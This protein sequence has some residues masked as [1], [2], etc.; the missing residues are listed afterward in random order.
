MRRKLI[1][2][3][4]KMNGAGNDFIVIDNRFFH[5]SG[6]ELSGLARTFC[7]RRTGIGADGLLA[8]AMPAEEGAHFTMHYYNADGSLGTM[9]GNGA[10][11]LV[12]FAR[13]AG[14]SAQPLVFDAVSGR[15]TA[16]VTEGENASVRIRMNPARD[17]RPRLQL[18]QESRPAQ[19]VDYVWTGTEHTVV[20][21]HDVDRE[22]VSGRGRAIR[23]ATELAPAGANVNFVEVIDAERDGVARLR[24]RT[25]EKGVEAETLACGT[26]ALAAAFAARR[27]G[28]VT[29]DCVEVTMPGGTLR[30]MTTPDEPDVLY[31]EGPA[32]FVYRG[33]VEID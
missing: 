16:W 9:C 26:G 11:C 20:W 30:V 29:A 6:D 18:S 27:S 22:D 15:Y 28:H 5:F 1:L 13:S 8:L 21:T 24:V 17:W 3:F 12:R 19:S 2:E 23:H 14:F 7:P 31:L 10:R 32:D 25:F 33:T 4:T